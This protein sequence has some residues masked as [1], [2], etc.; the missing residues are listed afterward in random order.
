MA[1]RSFVIHGQAVQKEFQLKILPVLKGWSAD[2]ELPPVSN[3]QVTSL[4]KRLSAPEEAEESAA[5]LRAC[6]AAFQVAERH[7]TGYLCFFYGLAAA[8]PAPDICIA[9]SR[10]VAAGLCKKLAGAYAE[11]DCDFSGSEG[12]GLAGRLLAKFF[13]DLLD[14]LGEEQYRCVPAHP[15][16]LEGDFLLPGAGALALK[17]L[18]EDVAIYLVVSLRALTRIVPVPLMKSDNEK[19]RVLKKRDYLQLCRTAGV[20]VEVRLPPVK[21]VISVINGLKVG[22]VLNLECELDRPIDLFIEG[23]KKSHQV[24]LGSLA[25]SKAIKIQTL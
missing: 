25:R 24:Y 13:G 22:D 16:D 19:T 2:W 21:A 14:R 17:V 6:L 4:P 11:Q 3:L 5:V 7:S 1:V 8:A 20:Q 12:H 23:Q 18:L 10:E 9:C 15:A